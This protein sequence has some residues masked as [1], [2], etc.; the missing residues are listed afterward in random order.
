MPTFFFLHRTR[1]WTTY[2]LTSL[3]LVLLVLL[4]NL[5]QE[6]RVRLWARLA[7]RLVPTAL[8]DLA[9]LLVLLLD[10][11]DEPYAVVVRLQ[12]ERLARLHEHIRHHVSR[13]HFEQRARVRI[14]DVLD[15]DQEALVRFACG[16]GLGLRRGGARF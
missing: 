8:H 14:V 5:H 9:R 3:S 12:L 4:R 2:V 7:H 11:E 10:D 16:L 13:A 6:I 15:R 1:R